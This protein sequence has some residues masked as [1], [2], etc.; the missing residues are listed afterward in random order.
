MSH[1]NRHP[2][3]PL[4]PADAP[5]LRDVELRGG[6]INNL[7]RCIANQPVLLQ[8]WTNFA[9]TLRRD[10]RAP[11]GLRELLILRAAQLSGSC[12]LWNDHVVFGRQA[13]L[14]QRKI[15]ELEH[16]ETSEVFSP[17][18]RSA[19]SFGDQ[20]VQRGGVDDKTL[21]EIAVHFPSDEIVELALTVGFYTMAPRVID[22]LRVPVSAQ[23]TPSTSF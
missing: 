4:L 22:A 5:P 9:W 13:G 10:C 7:Y 20:L 12:Y 17:A 23:P 1:T 19:L 15:D 2:G 18:E 6:R 8:A 11:R 3:V 21:G 14:P 16:W